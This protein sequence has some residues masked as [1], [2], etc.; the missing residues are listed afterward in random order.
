MRGISDGWRQD[1]LL[2]NR[3]SPG[4][5]SVDPM[6]Y[7]HCEAVRTERWKYT[8]YS[9]ENPVVEELFDLPND[10]GE[11]MNVASDL[12]HRGT[13]VYLRNRRE[14]LLAEASAGG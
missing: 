10:Y 11:A 1:L 9:K 2:E 12:E 14:E 6:Y 3:S 5:T 8:R 13:L 4:A 7:P